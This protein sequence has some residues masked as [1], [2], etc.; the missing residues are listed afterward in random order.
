MTEPALSPRAHRWL[1]AATGLVLLPHVTHLPFW[2]SGFV[3]ATGLLYASARRPPG[4]TVPRLLVLGLTLAGTAG[5][6]WQ[7]GT[8]LGRNA[9]VTLL[10]IMLSLKLLETRQRRDARLVI[11]TGY[12]VVITNF[13]FT[14]TPLIALYMFAI[15]IVITATLSVVTHDSD[16]SPARSHLRLA[17]TL[18]LQA[19]P[20]MVVLFVFFPRIVGPIWG[21]PKDAHAGVTGLSG[22]M[23]P[24]AISQLV[25]SGA[26]AFRVTFRGSAPVPEQRYWRGPVL[27]ETDGRTWTTGRFVLMATAPEA[28]IQPQGTPVQQEITL[29]SH[30]KRWLLAL[31]RP[32]TLSIPSIRTVGSEW[33]APK[34]VRERIRY[35]VT[36]YTGYRTGAL[37]PVLRDAALQLPKTLSKRLQELAQHW[38]RNTGDR[39]VVRK[40]LDYFHN[41]PFVY[42]LTP[43]PLGADPMDEFCSRPGAA[44]VNIMPRPLCC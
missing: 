36:S 18:L 2:V 29:E 39:A 3:L 27:W 35:T 41:E 17:G 26:T 6:L 44:S 34:A 7:Y 11:F 5:V 43:P 13:L 16:Q 9:G 23:R 21:L 14:Q 32:Y 24:G 10:V 1:L 33:L 12:F 42:T 31:D 25:E 19:L 20:V 8:L 30:N 4:S 40:A 22:S 37:N 15:T 28:L 38:R